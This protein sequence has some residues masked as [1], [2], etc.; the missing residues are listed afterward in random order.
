E[1]PVNG[2]K[3]LQVL[4]SR[5]RSACGQDAILRDGAGYRLG[6]APAE[7]DSVRL[8]ELVRDAAGALD[9]DAALASGLAHAALSLA[10]GLPLVNGDGAGPVAEVRRSAAA[11]VSAARVIQARALTRMG[12]HAAALPVLETAHAQQPR[13]EALL[14]DLLR[15]EA[16]ARG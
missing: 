1:P 13:D 16:A 3:S 9:R 5:T 4:V 2:L 11:D 6:V 12:E 8:T 10:D 14:A 7:V 15:S